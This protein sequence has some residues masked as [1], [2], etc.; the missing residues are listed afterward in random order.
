M[1]KSPLW[2]LRVHVVIRASFRS[3][4]LYGLPPPDLAGVREEH[5]AFP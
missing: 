5:T 1:R 3:A 2:L 4:C